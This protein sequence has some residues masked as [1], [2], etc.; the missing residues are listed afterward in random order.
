MTYDQFLQYHLPYI[1]SDPKFWIPHTDMH[2]RVCELVKFQM[3]T[4]EKIN[5]KA[6]EE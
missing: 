4:L 6:V 5:A 2:N 1:R 3:N